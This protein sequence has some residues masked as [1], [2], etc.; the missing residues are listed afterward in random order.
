M[1]NDGFIQMDY[2]QTQLASTMG[3][4]D[5]LSVHEKTFVKISRT[6]NEGGIKGQ[7]AAREVEQP[8]GFG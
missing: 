1:D 2:P 4:F 7:R 5:I 6:L 3:K 8:R